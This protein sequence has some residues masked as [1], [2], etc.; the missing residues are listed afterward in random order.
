MAD[1]RRIVVRLGE[2]IIAVSIQAYRVLETAS[3]PA[4]YIPPDECSLAAPAAASW[5]I[6]MRMERHRALLGAKNS[7]TNHAAGR[8]ELSKSL[9]S[10]RSALG[11]LF[12]L[13]SASGMLRGWRARAAA[14]W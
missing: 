9:R 1:G 6:R 2:L 3:P 8:L 12:F 13:S 4:F 7:G 5:F 10:V 14:T 11:L